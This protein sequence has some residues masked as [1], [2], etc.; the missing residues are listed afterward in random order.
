MPLTQLSAENAIVISAIIG[1]IGIVVGGVFGIMGYTKG[2]MPG[3]SRVPPTDVQLTQTKEHQAIMKA[4]EAIAYSQER[5]GATQQEIARTL[6]D[7]AQTGRETL[8][9]IAPRR[10]REL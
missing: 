9:F 8:D 5:Q 3:S 6:K 4:V 1:V 7:V 2:W 10:A